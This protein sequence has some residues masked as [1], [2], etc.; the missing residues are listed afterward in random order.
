MTLFDF[1]TA[2]TSTYMQGSTKVIH[3]SDAS[4]YTSEDGKIHTSATRNSLTLDGS[5][6]VLVNSEKFSHAG[7]VRQNSQRCEYV[8]IK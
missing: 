7:Q 8:K 2:I 4:E 6:M 5:Q 1:Y 3:N